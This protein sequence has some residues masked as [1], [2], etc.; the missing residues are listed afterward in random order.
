MKKLLI[1]ILSVVLL[2]ACTSRTKDKLEQFQKSTIT[3]GFDTTITMIGFAESQA[4][5]DEIFEKGREKFLYYHELFDIYN[6]YDDI[7]NLKTVNAAAGIEKVTVSE[8]IIDLLLLSKEYT[9]I[10]NYFDITYGSVYKVWHEYREEGIELN[11]Q[12]KPGNVPT[13]EELEEAAQYTGWDKVEIDAENNTVYLTEKGVRLDVGAVAKGYATEKVALYLEEIGLENGIVSGGGNI[14]TIN[15]KLDEPWKIGVQEPRPEKDAPSIDIFNIDESMSIVTSGDYQRTYYGP[16]NTF[17]SH[18]TNPN[19]LYPQTGF[20]SVS[21]VTKD[22]GLADIFSTALYM[23][24]YEE[25][26][27][28]VDKFNASHPENKIDVFWVVDD[29]P[30]WYHYENKQDDE[31]VEYYY[32]MTDGL[33]E[34]SR[35]LNR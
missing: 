8:D 3:A 23:M 24:S 6:N 1:I 9:N 28:F 34:I 22:S 25:G 31:T 16:D 32:T 7:N 20:R 13:L 33:K 10:S 4:A 15:G 5:F 26:L 30:D 14:R 2:T 12:G 35:N 18:L 29:N 21:I 19:T 11:T 17:Y 27:D